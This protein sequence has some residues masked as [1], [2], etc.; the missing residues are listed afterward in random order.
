MLPFYDLFH[1]GLEFFNHKDDF[2]RVLGLNGFSFLQLPVITIQSQFIYLNLKFDLIF[3]MC[4]SAGCQIVKSNVP[5]I[6]LQ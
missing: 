4:A 1:E 5:I 3:I 2:Y 6:W